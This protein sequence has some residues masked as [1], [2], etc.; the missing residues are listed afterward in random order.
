MKVLIYTLLLLLA[1]N[2]NY[3]FSQKTEKYSYQNYHTIGLGLARLDDKFLVGS[4]SSNSIGE[5]GFS[6]STD[7]IP[8]TVGN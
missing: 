7:L 6:L 1:S 4:C 5:S 2:N 3:L 8:K